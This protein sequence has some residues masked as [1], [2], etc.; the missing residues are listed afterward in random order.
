MSA[1]WEYF[2]TYLPLYSWHIQHRSKISFCMITRAS[3]TERKCLYHGRNLPSPTASNFPKLSAL[4]LRGASNIPES[5]LFS[6]HMPACSLEPHV[7]GLS[8]LGFACAPQSWTGQPRKSN[9]CLLEALYF[10]FHIPT[11]IRWGLFPVYNR[12]LPWHSLPPHTAPQGLELSPSSAPQPPVAWC[13]LLISG[14][15]HSQCHLKIYYLQ[16]EETSSYTIA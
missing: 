13:Q 2:P 8:T 15:W 16:K 5:L 9:L 1:S 7:V 3:A 4:P 14:T 11:F 12:P 10:L 6:S